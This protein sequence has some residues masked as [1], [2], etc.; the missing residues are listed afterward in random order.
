MKGPKPLKDS[1]K[2]LNSREKKELNRKLR[3]QWG[4]ELEKDMVFL[5]SNKGKLYIADRD[6]AKIDTGGMRVDNLGLYVATVDDKGMRLS[7]EG[8]QIIGPLA[9]KNVIDIGER[10]VREWFRGDDIAK[11][12]IETE[13]Q[14]GFVILKHGDDFIGCGKVTEKGILN[15]VPKTRR[16]LS[17]D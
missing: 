14:E 10:A 17:S 16:I 8:S 3:D 2:I 12:D 4:C 15:F 6:I 7:I 5:I 1:L 13:D 11:E 9:K